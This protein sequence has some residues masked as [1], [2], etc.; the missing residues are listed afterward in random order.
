MLGTWQRGMVSDEEKIDLNGESKRKYKDM[1][2]K[3]ADQNPG[4]RVNE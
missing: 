4:Y 1:A 2:D 3:M